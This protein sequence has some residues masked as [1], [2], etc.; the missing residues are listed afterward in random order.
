MHCHYS[1]R[2]Y[3]YTLGCFSGEPWLMQVEIPRIKVFTYAYVIEHSNI[4]AR[5]YNIHKISQ[6]KKKKF[7]EDELKRSWCDWL[8]GEGKSEPRSDK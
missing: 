6:V 5:G 4:S 3:Y 8:V 7:Q 1:I 2:V